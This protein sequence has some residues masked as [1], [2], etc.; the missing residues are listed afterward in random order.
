[1]LSTELE[2]KKLELQREL[3]T[4]PSRTELVELHGQ[5]KKELTDIQFGVDIFLF[6]LYIYLID[7]Q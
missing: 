2:R 6:L 4:G 3:S 5:N 1:M 7:K